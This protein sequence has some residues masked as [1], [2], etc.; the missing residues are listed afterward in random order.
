[1]SCEELY[2]RFDF[3]M[4]T[5]RR[6]PTSYLLQQVQRQSIVIVR[7]ATE[8]HTCRMDHGGKDKCK[9]EAS[10][11][12]HGVVLAF[13]DSICNGKAGIVFQVIGN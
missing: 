8:I 7:A 5:Q 4:A 11:D 12:I 10:L 13:T 6:F 9:I 3:F 2:K 1:M